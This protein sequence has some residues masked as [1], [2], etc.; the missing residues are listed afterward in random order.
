LA[1][2]L[3]D[4]GYATGAFVGA[5]VLDARFGLNHGFNTYDDRYGERRRGDDTEFAERR[6]EAVM[7]SALNWIV[8]RQSDQP[9]FAWVHFFDPHTPYDAPDSFAADREPYDAEVAYADATLGSMIRKLKL[10]RTLVVV[11][12]DHGESLGEHGERTHGVFAYDATLRVPLVLWTESGLEPRVVESPARLVDLAPTLLDL[13]DVTIPDTMEG[14]S[15]RSVMNGTAE[16]V[17]PAYFE[18][19]NAHLARNWAPLTGV[20][21]DGTKL[22]DLPIP[23]LYETARDPG[24]TKNLYEEQPEKA[25][26]LAAQLEELHKNFATRTPSTPRVALTSEE[27]ARLEALGYVASSFTPRVSLYTEEDDPKALIESANRLDDANAAFDRG[28]TPRGIA[29]ARAVIEENPRFTSAYV[30]LATMLRRRGELDEAVS[31]LERAVD[32]NRRDPSLVVT[33]GVTLQEAGRLSES[34]RVLEELLDAHPDYVDGMSVLATTYE[35]MGRSAEARATY[36]SILDLDPTAAG[37]FDRLGVLE[38][39][40]GRPDVALGHLEHAVAFDPGLAGAHS[41][42]GLARAQTGDSPGAIEAWKRAL[43]LD[44]YQYGTLFNLGMHLVSL[45]RDEEA[46]PYLS[47]FAAEAPPERYAA[48]I[49]RAEQLL[50]R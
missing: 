46:M 22:I 30:V 7:E 17:P 5:F 11:T 48:Q 19:M 9:W 21:V 14:R 1:G 34:A 31:L 43:E 6:A 23:E 10:E 15:L 8:S 35:R 32:G 26:V 36:M 13:L 40:E 47:R 38:I 27:R 24:E 28:E 49:R 44:G 33:L 50:G 18:A 41:A 12:S 37:V 39:R 3:R 16:P 29:E 4:Q 2:L 45:G 25:Q 20:V 42:L